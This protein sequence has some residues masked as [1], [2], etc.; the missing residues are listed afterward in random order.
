MITEGH[1]RHW[2][3]AVTL[4]LL[5]C[6]CMTFLALAFA[7]G[8]W[9][10]DLA[11]D[12]MSAASLTNYPMRDTAFLWDHLADRFEQEWGQKRVLAQF[13]QDW[14]WLKY[15][16]LLFLPLSILAVRY[17]HLRPASTADP[18]RSRNR[19]MLAVGPKVSV[20][21]CLLFC[22]AVAGGVIAMLSIQ[23]LLATHFLV[24][25]VELAVALP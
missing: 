15:F 6:A 3:V 5:S 8:K 12:F 4:W 18:L 22:V 9:A 25:P 2:H 14:Q 11:L 7:L 1:Q 10:Y 20:A 23:A 21:I 17:I 16:M 13:A 24:R 19:T